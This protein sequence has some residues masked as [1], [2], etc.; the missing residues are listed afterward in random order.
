[1]LHVPSPPSPRGTGTTHCT[2]H[3]THYMPCSLTKQ[4]R[5]YYILL[6]TWYL[7]L[8]GCCVWPMPKSACLSLFR[9]SKPERVTIYNPRKQCG[10]QV[11]SGPGPGPRSNPGSSPRSGPVVD[12]SKCLVP[13]TYVRIKPPAILHSKRQKKKGRQLRVHTLAMLTVLRIRSGL[14]LSR[15][16]SAQCRLSQVTIAATMARWWGYANVRLRHPRR[17]RQPATGHTL[18]LG[19]CGA[20]PCDATRRGGAGRDETIARVRENRPKAN[21]LLLLLLLQ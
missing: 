21:A 6:H 17:R 16:H 4:H 9:L 10:G 7:V 14:R 8:V 15:A 1:M 20:M 19:V 2:L 3:T 18:R 12:C 5:H 13:R 11:R